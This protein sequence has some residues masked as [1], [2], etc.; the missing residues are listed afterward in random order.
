MTHKES[1]FF[2]YDKRFRKSCPSVKFVNDTTA[3][4]LS[5]IA[6]QLAKNK[7]QISE[8]ETVQWSNNNNMK[9]NAAKTKEMLICFHSGHDVFPQL[10][11]N[12][13][14]IE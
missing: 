2:N 11:F 3:Y 8:N 4:D 7:L 10:V 6:Q 12:E 1:C 13:C 5:T 9:L 14:V